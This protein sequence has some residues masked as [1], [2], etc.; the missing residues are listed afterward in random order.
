MG[1]RPSKGTNKDK[2][3]KSNRG[4]KSRNSGRKRKKVLR[5]L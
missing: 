5:W 4:N 1:G 3:L 2:R